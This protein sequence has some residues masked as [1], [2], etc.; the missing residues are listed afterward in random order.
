MKNKT[1]FE[2]ISD[3]RMCLYRL[4]YEH[5][6]SEPEQLLLDMISNSMDSMGEDLQT[7]F[8]EMK[9][10]RTDIKKWKESLHK[11]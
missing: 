7:L 8:E 2:K 11:D 4:K 1:V 10:S 9:K 3:I 6:N 5:C